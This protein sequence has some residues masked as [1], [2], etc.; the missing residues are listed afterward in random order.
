MLASF[1]ISLVFSV[2]AAHAGLLPTKSGNFQE[3]DDPCQQYSLCGSKG[4]TYWQDLTKTLAIP[5]PM[6]KPDDYFIY[7]NWYRCTLEDRSG[8]GQQIQEDLIH[9]GFSP[10]NDYKMWH[11]SSLQSKNGQADEETSYENMVNTDD[12]VIIATYNWRPLD[13]QKKLQWYLMESSSGFS[14]I[15]M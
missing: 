9:R 4:F 15:L 3:M 13:S 1:L 12:G 11:V 10:I 6:D 7:K 14:S 8:G 2:S 5:Y